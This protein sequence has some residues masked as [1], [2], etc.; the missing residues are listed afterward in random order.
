MDA[1]G[2]SGHNE[3]PMRRGKQEMAKF[4]MSLCVTAR[5]SVTIE[6]TAVHASEI[7]MVSNLS[8]HF[9]VSNDHWWNL[10][11]LECPPPQFTLGLYVQVRVLKVGC[12]HADDT[13]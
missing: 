5:H 7:C 8:I 11:R 9:C 3:Y 6:K 13:F 10:Q 1:P 4:E 2:D 12:V